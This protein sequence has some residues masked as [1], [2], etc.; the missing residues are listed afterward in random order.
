[1]E[2]IIS[3]YKGGRHTQSS[4]QM[5]VVVEGLDSKEKAAALV[6]KKTVWTSPAGKEIKGEVKSAHGNSGALRVAFETGMP[7]QAISTKVKIE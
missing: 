5:I 7:G 3:N 2:G 4:N 6:G 1:M